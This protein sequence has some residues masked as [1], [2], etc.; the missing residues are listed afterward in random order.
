MYWQLTIPENDPEKLSA[1]I[2]VQA[3]NWLSALK[4]GL[5]KHGVDS[6]LVTNLSCRV[7]PDQSV[8]IT[9]FITGRTYTLKSLDPSARATDKVDAPQTQEDEPVESGGDPPDDLIPHTVFFARDEAPSD[10]SGIY[11]R[12]RLLAV[13]ADTTEPEASRLIHAQFKQLK[14]L[15]A[16]NQNQLFISL[17]IFDHSFTEAS[18]RPALAALTWREWYPDKP[19]ILFPLSGEEGITFSKL[20]GAPAPTA[21]PKDDPPK[22]RRVRS[23]TPPPGDIFAVDDKMIVAFERMQ[24]IYGVESHDEAADFGLSLSMRLVDCEAGSIMLFTPGKYELYVAAAEGPKSKQLK[25]RKISLKRGIIGFATRNSAVINVSE[26]HN[27]ERFDSDIDTQTGFETRNVLCAPIQ[28]EG[29]TLGAIELLNSP[30]EAGFEQ[31]EVNILAYIGSTL[32][33][34]IEKSLPSREADFQDKDFQG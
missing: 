5:Q 17:Q 20:P 23:L 13:D 30:H 9:D 32:A 16:K 31:D 19:K 11:Y 7:Q 2:T 24:H 14:A 8:M 12:E 29:R 15:G 27:D 25:N 1:S 34:Y 33:E 26:P 22:K 28:Y 6:K 10:D 4:E 3:D 18:E 21:V